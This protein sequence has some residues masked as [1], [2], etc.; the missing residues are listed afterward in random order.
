M[1]D[2]M[3]N[4]L[5]WVRKDAVIIIVCILALAGCVYTLLHGDSIVANCNAHWQEQWEKAQ[6]FIPDHDRE[7][8]NVF[9]VEGFNYTGDD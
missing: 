8:V 4:V 3:N 5:V 6:C 1:D 2:T 7:P 9:K